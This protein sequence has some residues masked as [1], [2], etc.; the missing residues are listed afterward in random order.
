[1]NNILEQLEKSREEFNRKVNELR[2]SGIIDNLQSEIVDFGFRVQ[3]GNELFKIVDFSNIEDW[4]TQQQILLL[5]TVEKEFKEI[6][7]KAVEETTKEH[8]SSNAY[9][10]MVGELALEDLINLIDKAIK[11]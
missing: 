1:M 3:K 9:I 2:N 8:K 10:D 11:K 5:E 4:H 7:T 6:I